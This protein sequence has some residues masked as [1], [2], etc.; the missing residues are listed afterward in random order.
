MMI[1]IPTKKTK[2]ICT[3]GPQEEDPVLMRKLFDAGMDVARFN[4][5]HG[6]HEE[7][8]GRIATLKKVREETK[9]P[10]AMLLDTKG[11]EIRTGLLVD[12]KKVL[13]EAGKTVTLTAGDFLGT[14]EH[15]AIT[16]DKLCEDV[17]EGSTVLIDDGLIELRVEKVDG[18]DILCQILNGGEVS[19]RKGINVPGVRTQ[20]PAITEKDVDDIL[21][22]I[23]QGF[24]ILA[25]SFIRDAEGVRQIRK[26][27]RDNGSFMPIY[28]KIE[29]SEA[30]ENID[31][32]IDES[33]GIMVARGDLGVEIPNYEV[34]YW[35][36]LIIDKCN[37]AYKPVITATQMLESMI[38][39]PRPT[40][41]EVTDVA[42]AI[43]DGTDAIMLSGETAVG[44]YPV[45][46]VTLMSQVAQT[47]ETHFDAERFI[48]HRVM[49]EDDN[50]SS[51]VCIASVRTARNVNAKAII[52]PTQFGQTAR[53][54]S[55]FRPTMPMIAVTPNSTV[56]R[57]MMAYWG[58]T[59]IIGEQ[60][61]ATQDIIQQAID[62]AKEFGLV[63][64]GDLCVIT[65]G[66]PVTNDIAG[67]G[68]VT[69]MMY[70][71]EVK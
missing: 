9:K 36:K 31:E 18:K 52:I 67:V 43:Y 24:D 47:T 45:E 53:L 30:L 22:G 41:A 62:Q 25:A 40:R 4:F 37:K 12:H 58:V 69:N 21:W 64:A 19:E 3:M 16:Y 11:P 5:S 54:M 23:T 39:Y 50:I 10:V 68:H 49:E 26:L 38:Y 70:V 14:A 6:T 1:V 17:K 48:R 55:N 44:K 57:R 32:I 63:K 8:L 7:Q 28:S 51:A 59:P 56:Q 65:A 2:I 33:D 29:C 66:D 27:L 35:Q 60:K 71:I 34:P 46:A 42:N 20:L 61:D 13:L 15:L